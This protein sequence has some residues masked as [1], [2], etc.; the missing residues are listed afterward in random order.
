MYLTVRKFRRPRVLDD[1]IIAVHRVRAVA[2]RRDA[3][4]NAFAFDFGVV[5]HVDRNEA[6]AL[7][8]ASL[9]AQAEHVGVDARR[10]G[11]VV[12]NECRHLRLVRRVAR[13][14]VEKAIIRAHDHL[15]LVV[16]A[17]IPGHRRVGVWVGAD[18]GYD[19]GRGAVHELASNDGK[20]NATILSLSLPSSL[21]L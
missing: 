6:I 20:V 7:C 3:M 21:A 5:A 12:M 14:G 10:Y 11:A 8:L 19:A 4:V 13:G 2:N 17:R 15:A 9:F 1:P 16:S 18:V